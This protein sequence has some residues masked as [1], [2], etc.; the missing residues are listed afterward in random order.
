MSQNGDLAFFVREE[1][2]NPE[3]ILFRILAYLGSTKILVANRTRGES[4]GWDQWRAAIDDDDI[5]PYEPAFEIC[6]CGP[7]SSLIGS[8]RPGTMLKVSLS[9]SIISEP[10]WKAHDKIDSKIRGDFQP[11]SPIVQIGFHDL[12]HEDGE[13]EMHYIARAFC[14]LRMFG[15][16]TPSDEP[17][18]KKKIW[19]LDFIK[20]FEED[21]SAIL[22][23][24]VVEHACFWSY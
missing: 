8:Y 9:D 23:P 10:F 17:A 20:R 1:F 5:S 24:C 12:F 7:L 2:T 4:K 6:K 19:G 18:Y 22:K 14:S 3:N 13:G 11:A 16:G 21:I 15:Y